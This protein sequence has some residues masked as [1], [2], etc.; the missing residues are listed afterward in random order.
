MNVVM[1][2]FTGKIDHYEP[3]IRAT[4]LNLEIYQQLRGK[5]N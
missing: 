1:T 3:D 2:L 5:A 4:D